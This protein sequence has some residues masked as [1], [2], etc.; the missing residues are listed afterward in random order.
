MSPEMRPKSFRTFEKRVPGLYK[1]I[2]GKLVL[3]SQ[4]MVLELTLSKLYQF[5]IYKKN[6]V[7]MQYET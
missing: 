5:L 2:L 1:G 6:E 4:N 3:A 7:T